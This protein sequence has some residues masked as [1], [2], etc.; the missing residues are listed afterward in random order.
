MNTVMGEPTCCDAAPPPVG[1]VVD[2][3]NDDIVGVGVVMI[4]VAPGVFAGTMPVTVVP[5]GCGAVTVGP[6]TGTGGADGMH[7]GGV[8]GLKFE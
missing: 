3:V 7:I 6:V 4:V 1:N 5:L 2:V 8:A